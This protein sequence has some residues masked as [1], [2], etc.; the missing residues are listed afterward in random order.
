MKFKAN[1]ITYIKDVFGVIHQIDREPFTYNAAYSAIY[2]NPERVRKSEILQALRYSFCIGAHG[3]PINSLTDTGY[4]NGAFMRFAKQQTKLV[5]GF[6][7][8]DVPVPDGCYRTDKYDPV[9]VVTFFDCLEHIPDLMF[10]RDIPAETIVISLPYCHFET[11]GLSWFENDYFH[12]KKNEHLHHFDQHS[13]VAFMDNM[14]WYCTA[15]G[16]LED[17]VRH[18]ESEP[19]WNILT[20]AFKRKEEIWKD[21][22]GEEG[23]YMISSFGRVR[24][25]SRPKYKSKDKI[26]SPVV[27][28]GGYLQVSFPT[29]NRQNKRNMIHRLVCS[30]FHENFDNKPMVNH[31]NGVV[32]HNYATNVEWATAQENVQHG[33]D[34]NG[35]VM[36]QSAQ[37]KPIKQICKTT[38]AVIK[39]W[40]SGLQMQKEGGYGR[41][42]IKQAIEK[43]K[44]YYGFFWEYA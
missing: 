21:V 26:L 33:F 13:L 11:R 28:R 17:L 5:G 4:G 29:E 34:N 40:E 42:A 30:H 7:I 9:D 16:N 35:R 25:L 15:V 14:G 37:R 8:T 31:K 1:G 32:W 41:M 20:C 2:D 18:R 27:A 36:D 12:L 22:K 43:K 44:P 23:R 39:V 19:E 3:R 38:G 24:S 10:V 6:D